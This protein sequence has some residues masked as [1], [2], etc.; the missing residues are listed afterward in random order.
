VQWPYR[1]TE[2]INIQLATQSLLNSSWFDP[3]KKNPYTKWH[4]L[5]TT[6]FKNSIQCEAFQM[7]N[8]AYTYNMWTN[9]CKKYPSLITQ[10][11]NPTQTCG[12]W[13]NHKVASTCRTTIYTSPRLCKVCWYVKSTFRSAASIVSLIL[14][15]SIMPPPPPL[16]IKL[17]IVESN[18]WS[19]SGLNSVTAKTCNSQAD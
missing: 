1:T 15:P 5:D 3:K 8:Q 9:K 13:E 2:K 6:S 12:V 11:I 10:H 14:S 18:Y 4:S 7:P 19:L 16:E 17:N